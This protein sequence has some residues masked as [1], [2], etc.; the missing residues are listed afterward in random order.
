MSFPQARKLSGDGE[1]FCKKRK[2]LDKPEL[3]NKELWQ[4]PRILNYLT[5]AFALCFN[6]V[7]LRD[8]PVRPG[9]RGGSVSCRF[10]EN[11]NLP[12]NRGE[13]FFMGF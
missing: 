1:S 13:G 10:R 8:G 2:I 4:R 5:D 11:N 9:G 3:Q 7:A 12:L 6:I